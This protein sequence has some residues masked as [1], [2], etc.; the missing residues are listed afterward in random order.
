MKAFKLFYRIN[1][2]LVLFLGTGW[3]YFYWLILTKHIE[4][5]PH[6]MT[7]NS[8]ILGLNLLF[9]A[10]LVLLPISYQRRK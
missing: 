8:V 6:A 5:M 9:A 10:S 4:K 2:G 1:L 3:F 7:M